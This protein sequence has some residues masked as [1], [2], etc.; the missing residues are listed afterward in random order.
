MNR[1]IIHKNDAI[2]RENARAAISGLDPDK[3]WSVEIKRYRK[4]RSLDQNAFFW[5]VPIKIICDHTGHSAEDIKEYL[6]GEWGGW[7]DYDVRD[8][9]FTRPVWRSTTLLSTLEFTH[10]LEWIESWAAQTLGLAIPRPNE[11]V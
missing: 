4:K 5:A 7:E 1:F 9:K 8:H 10:F 3:E 2:R 6:L 11:T